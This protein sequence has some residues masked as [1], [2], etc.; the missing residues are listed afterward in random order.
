MTAAPLPA[1]AWD[2]PGRSRAVHPAQPSV[3]G[4]ALR[5][6]ALVAI[7]HGPVRLGH[8]LG[9]SSHAIHR[10]LTGE[11]A[12]IPP[13]R[14]RMITALYEEWWDLAPPERTRGERYAATAA[15][16]RAQ[17]EG[18]CAGAGLDDERLDQPGYVPQ[19]SWRPA[20]GTGVATDNPLRAVS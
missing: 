17:R 18:W 9:T 8:A 2:G 15:R 6:R 19:W 20:T 5:L 14:R 4:C 12:D 16:R 1:C 11:T 13:Q 7:G 3:S 10:I